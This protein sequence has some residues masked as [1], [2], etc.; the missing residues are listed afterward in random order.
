MEIIWYRILDLGFTKRDMVI[1]KNYITKL[2]N[3]IYITTEEFLN[4]MIERVEIVESDVETAFSDLLT[5]AWDLIIDQNV[6]QII[7][8]NNL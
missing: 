8:E 2:L 4:Y 1:V 5:D 3:R 7:K 6:L